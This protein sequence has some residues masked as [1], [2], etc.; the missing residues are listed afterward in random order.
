MT[1][2]KENKIRNLSLEELESAVAGNFD[3]DKLTYEEKVRYYTL[4]NR[5]VDLLNLQA[6]D[7]CTV[8]EVIAAQKEVVEY[9]EALKLK[10]PR[11]PKNAE[12][13]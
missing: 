8:E 6:K 3:L 7:K 5:F 10:Y 13:K 9:S 11:V 1:K 4:K 12:I 2:N